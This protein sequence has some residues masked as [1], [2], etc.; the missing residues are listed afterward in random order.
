MKNRAMNVSVACLVALLALPAPGQRSPDLRRSQRGSQRTG[1]VFELVSCSLGCVRGPSGFACAQ[2]EVH[3]NEELRFTFTRPIAL[4]SVNVNTFQVADLGT[5]RI[6]PASLRLDPS[7]PRTLVYRPLISFDSAGNPIPGMEEDHTYILRIPGQTLDTLGP[8]ITSADGS[9]N[10]AR[11][12]CTLIASLG[13]MDPVP[14]RPFAKIYVRV[15]TARDPVTGEPIAFAI[16]P[17][18]GAVEVHRESAIEIV[19][20]D[21]MNPASIGNPI[22]GLS[23]TIRLFFDPDGD[24]TGVGD[25]VPIAGHVTMTFDADRPVTRVRFQPDG[26]LPA[27]GP[28]RRPG[29]VVVQLH[30]TIQDLGGNTLANPGSTSFTPEA[31]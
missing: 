21:T 7:D 14:G 29:R 18:E 28:Q 8:W 31:R 17:A 13:F 10:Q 16:V 9:P 1:D 4:S 19:F 22:T 26:S 25:Q 5:G 15:V 23:H 11:L 12:Q 27:A 3:V 30:P 6:P 2:N 24:V 20:G